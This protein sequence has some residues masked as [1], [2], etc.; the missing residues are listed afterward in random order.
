MGHSGAIAA[1]RRLASTGTP[2]GV[3][4]SSST[5]TLTACG[6]ST[7]LTKYYDDGA[8]PI[9]NGTVL[10]NDAALTTVYTGATKDYHKIG[11]G[12]RAYISSV[13]GAL[14]NFGLCF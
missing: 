11:V 14:S 1:A 13:T 8:G 12:S 3:S 6:F 9:G 5:S 4:T 10:Y 7:D 2:I